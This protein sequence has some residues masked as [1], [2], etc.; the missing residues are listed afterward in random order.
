MSRRY[1]VETL[2]C[3]KN[4]VDSAKLVGTLQADGFSPADR[5]ESADV[6]VVN[7]CAFVEAARQ[8]SIDTVLALADRRQEGARLVVT[9]CLAERYGDELAAALPEADQVSGFGVPVTL[10]TRTPGAPPIP[11]FDLLNLPRPRSSA[12]WAYVKVA[13][14]CDRA[15]GFCAIPSF[16]GKQRSRSMESILAEVDA[17]EV[18]E[19]VLVAQD[20]AS[21]GRDIGR[22]GDIIPL[23]EAVSRKVA[24]T[25]LLYLYP[26]ELTDGLIDVMGGTRCPYFDLSLQ[27]ASRPHLRRMRRWGDSARFAERIATIRRRYPEAAFRSSFIVGYP[28]ETEDDHDELLEFLESA[29]LDWAGFFPF[30]SEVGTYAATLPN[31]VAPALMAERLLECGEL[32]DDITANRRAQL[33]G[34]TVEVLVD[35]PGQA[36][37]HREAP[38]IDGVVE[39]PLEATRGLVGRFVTARVTGSAGPDL[40]AELAVV[41]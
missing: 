9:G 30:S 10:S 4:E 27:H 35:R 37:G 6:V 13:E 17:L 28:G 31:R 25:R 24:R 22:H 15:C 5:P 1:W 19:V 3:P 14:G 20:L 33:I 36:R 2:G 40:E 21:Y 38:E 39:L 23:V 7:T 34:R 8:E 11:S 41:A 16:R 29:Q 26:S 12:P 32:Q 18:E